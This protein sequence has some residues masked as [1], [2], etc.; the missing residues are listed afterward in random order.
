MQKRE[1]IFEVEPYIKIPLDLEW[2]YYHIPAKLYG[3]PE[4]CYPEEEESEII[5]CEGWKEK[6]R[7]KFAEAAEEFIK[8]MPDKVYDLELWNKPLE[9]A[10]EA[11]ADYE[12]SRAAEIMEERRFAA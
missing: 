9:W 11:K 4:F 3:P 12:E 1:H 7:A 10:A 5:L 6:I 8:A 2:S